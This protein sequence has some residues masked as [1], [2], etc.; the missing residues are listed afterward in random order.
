MTHAV[1]IFFSLCAS[2]S[3]RELFRSLLNSVT[4]GGIVLPPTCKINYVNMQNIY[5]IKLYNNVDMQ[6]NLFCML[7]KYVSI[8]HDDRYMTYNNIIEFNILTKFILHVA[9]EVCQH[10]YQLIIVTCFYGKTKLRYLSWPTSGLGCTEVSASH[11][12]LRSSC[13]PFRE[14]YAW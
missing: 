10:S 9:T 14:T 5:F 7:K 8:I 13:L 1:H 6:H 3:K 12:V 2:C 11:S 4:Y